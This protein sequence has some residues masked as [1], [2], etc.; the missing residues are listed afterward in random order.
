M[1]RKMY[2][3]SACVHK[4]ICDDRKLLCV[5]EMRLFFKCLPDQTLMFKNTN[6]HG[7]KLSKG[8]VTL[9]FAINMD[10]SENMRPIL[11]PLNLG[12]LKINIFADNV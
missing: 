7:R 2:G 3:G 1:F 9:F 6:W 10:D 5:V 8:W 11:S 4:G 12:N